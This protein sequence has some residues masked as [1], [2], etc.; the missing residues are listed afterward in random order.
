MI[1]YALKPDK[2]TYFIH[3]KVGEKIQIYNKDDCNI[4]FESAANGPACLINGM[5]IH[6]LHN[7]NSTRHCYSMPLTDLT[8]KKRLSWA[9]ATER[10]SGY[11]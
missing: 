1:W 3:N 7:G 9:K 11:I 2:S 8:T 10:L 5:I 6:T 4:V